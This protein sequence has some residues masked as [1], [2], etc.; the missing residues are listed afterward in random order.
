MN[1]IA[2]KLRKYLPNQPKI[3]IIP[4]PEIDHMGQII[5]EVHETVYGYLEVSSSQELVSFHLDILEDEDTHVLINSQHKK[6][7]EEEIMAVGDKFANEFYSRPVSLSGLFQWEPDTYL[8]IYEEKDQELGLLIP[9]TGCMVNVDIYGHVTSASFLDV[10]YKLLFPE[11]KI[12]SEEAKELICQES[13]V[14]LA[15]SLEEKPE[16][17]Y[18]PIHDIAGVSVDGKIQRSTELLEFD[19]KSDQPIEKVVVEF[20]MEELLGLAESDQKII[21]EEQ[22]YWMRNG[23]EEPVAI[24]NKEDPQHLFYQSFSEWSKDAG[25]L[26]EEVLRKRAIQFLESVIG[27]VHE[28]YVEEFQPSLDDF[29]FTEE[30]EE[31]LIDLYESTSTFLFKRV[32]NGI[33]VPPYSVEVRIGKCSGIIRY[34]IIP[35]ISQEQLEEVVQEKPRITIE[36]ANGIYKDTLTMKLVRSVDH[37][38]TPSIYG[39]S[40]LIDFP[41]GLHIEKINAHT[42]EV[43]F[44]DSGLIREG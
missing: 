3:K 15:I 31:D 22:T 28:K 27:N 30:E 13:L 2:T 1:S 5:D 6:L 21:E 17:V 9:N 20:S 34:A 7:N 29:P 8:V 12:N 40:Y 25:T 39:L 24:I 41:N 38:Q 32:Y 11:I 33:P 19:T 4:D 35:V 10:D 44:V 36:E 18:Y 37:I 16:L 43:Q 26:D 42:G 14:Q 23:E